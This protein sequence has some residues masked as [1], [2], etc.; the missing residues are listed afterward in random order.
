MAQTL[1]SQITYDF[2][3][4]SVPVK[5]DEDRPELVKFT[6]FKD[7]LTKVEVSHGQHILQQNQEALRVAE[8]IDDQAITSLDSGTATLPQ[9]ID[10][11]N[12]VTTILNNLIIRGKQ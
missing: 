1:T 2:M 12:K 5:L 3:G 9:T 8:F 4:S 7:A 11:L 10:M 6:D